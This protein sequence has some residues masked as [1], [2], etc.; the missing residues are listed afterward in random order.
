MRLMFVSAV[1]VLATAGTAYAS[2]PASGIGL[3]AVCCEILA[4]CCRTGGCC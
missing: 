3:M 2:A 1:S 4:A